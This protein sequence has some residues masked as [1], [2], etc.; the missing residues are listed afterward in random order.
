MLS[1]SVLPLWPSRPAAATWP[2]ASTLYGAAFRNGVFN[3]IC[4]VTITN[5]S[6][7]DTVVTVTP[8][9]YPGV[10][11]TV[12][13]KQSRVWGAT[14]IPSGVETW[15]TAQSNNGASL[16]GT[17]RCRATDSSLDSLAVDEMIPSSG[18]ATIPFIPSAGG[19]YFV[20]APQNG[21]AYRISDGA[22]LGAV[23]GYSWT[24]PGAD[25]GY[26]RG[27]AAQVMRGNGITS[28]GGRAS[29]TALPDAYAGRTVVFPRV[30]KDSGALPQ[31]SLLNLVNVG[32]SS[33]TINLTAYEQ[34][35]GNTSTYG[36]L[37]LP[38]N[39]AVRI[40]IPEDWNPPFGPMSV[41]AEAQEAGA[42]LLGSVSVYRG[43]TNWL[44]ASI[45][46]MDLSAAPSGQRAFATLTRATFRRNVPTGE[47]TGI[48]VMNTSRHNNVPI[49][50]VL[51]N[52]SGAVL[53]NNVYTLNAFRRQA[54][55]LTDDTTYPAGEYSV[56]AYPAVVH[57][58]IK[59]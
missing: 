29:M 50:V 18:A 30:F 9:G 52:A 46:F 40:R 34:G 36:P 10:A 33:A 39:R 51:R 13:A 22:T 42:Q 45:T 58:L 14:I 31:G 57:C 44:P 2:P 23:S 54:I 53:L 38:A 59:M 26:V 4:S 24:K 37:T 48:V 41:V 56:E 35:T 19:G 49:R 21:T 27:N 55:L 11:E 17:I 28:G 7:F 20:G 16:T 8:N 6:D 12:P 1:L 5:W 47:G 15:V 25:E 3:T 43:S 32:T